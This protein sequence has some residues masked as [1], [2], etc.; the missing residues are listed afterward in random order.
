MNR[1]PKPRT[2][3]LSATA[4]LLA[5]IF[6]ASCAGTGGGTTTAPETGA[7]IPSGDSTSAVVTDEQTEAVT[8]PVFADA[9]Y[10]GEAFTVYMRV[11]STYSAEYIDAENE[12]G[13]LMN[14]SVWRRNLRVEE[15][16]KVKIETKTASTPYKQLDK[17]ISSGSLDYDLIL[18][19]RGEL[20]TSSVSG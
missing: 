8:E 20:A 3:I 4:L 2:A 15:K 9:D 5:A 14:D 17:D 1:F 16:Y 12:N 18:D 6:L 7:V 10:T 11:N 13:D 19:R